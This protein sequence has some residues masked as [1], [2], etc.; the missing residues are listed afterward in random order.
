L[1]LKPAAAAI[2]AGNCV[3]VKPSEVTPNVSNVI[4]E[5]FDTYMDKDCYRALEGGI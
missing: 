4:K 1:C 2:S 3:C 5:L